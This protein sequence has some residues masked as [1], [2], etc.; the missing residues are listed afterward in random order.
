MLPVYLHTEPG[1]PVHNPCAAT[2]IYLFS[3]INFFNE[4]NQKPFHSRSYRWIQTAV[5][6]LHRERSNEFSLRLQKVTGKMLGRGLREQE[7]RSVLSCLNDLFNVNVHSQ[8]TEMNI[9]STTL[10]S[11]NYALNYGLRL[12]QASL[13]WTPRVSEKAFKRSFTVWL[14]GALVTRQTTFPYSFLPQ[15]ERGRENPQGGSGWV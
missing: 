1:W 7:R 4:M 11:T 10:I 13:N 14:P 12:Y 15:K 9:Y 5:A 3:E 8:A 2:P 6:Y